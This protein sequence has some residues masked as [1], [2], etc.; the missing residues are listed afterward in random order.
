MVCPGERAQLADEVKRAE[1]VRQFAARILNSCVIYFAP[2][3]RAHNESARVRAA[4]SARVRH[5]T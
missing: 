3:S 4:P 1:F 2:P 5:P